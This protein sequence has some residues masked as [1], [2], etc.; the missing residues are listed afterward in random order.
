MGLLGEAMFMSAIGQ[1]SEYLWL[2]IFAAW[3]SALT[4]FLL[5]E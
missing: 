4:I 1:C 3:L 5:S 2:W